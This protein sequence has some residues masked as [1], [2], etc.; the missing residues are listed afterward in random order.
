MYKLLPL[1]TVKR[2]QIALMLL[3]TSMLSGCSMDQLAADDQYV[4]STHYEQY[5]INVAK[6]PIK[7]E[8][9]SQHAALQ[10]SQINAISRFAHS[11]K[12][13]S[14]S[15]I[16]V[17]RPSGGGASNLV[18]NETYRLLIKSGIAAGMI[19]QGTYPGPAKGPIQITYISSVA[20]TKECGDWSSDVADSSGNG[21]Q[22]NMGC[23][24]Q[25]NIAAMVVNPEDFVVP[26]AT[27]PVVA[28]T[29]M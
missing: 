8:I 15:K 2:T 18:A 27:T 19:V 13:A 3:A 17:R 20:V 24:V 29:R 21:L 28:A 9:S 22:S 23:A 12:N 25:N 6:A 5:P 14:V 16:N 4:P 1:S 7:L 11:A 10:P 26:R